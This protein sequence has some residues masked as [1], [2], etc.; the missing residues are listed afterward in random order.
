MSVLDQIMQMKGQGISDEE[1]VG[2]LAQQGI[3]PK[4]INDALKQAQIKNAV[5][6]DDEQLQPSIAQG[7]EAP[8]PSQNYGTQEYQPQEAYQ[9]QPEASQQ[10]YYAAEGGGQQQGYAPE[11][12]NTDTVMEIADQVFSDKIKKIQKQVDTTS[13]T[14]NLLQ[15]KTDNISERLKKIESII[16]RL[17]MSIL[18]KIGSY[19]DN[20]E[21]IKNE[22]SMMQDS[23]TKMVSPS[24]EQLRQQTYP[25]E[26]TNEMGTEQGSQ[27]KIIRKK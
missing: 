7:G 16:D 22:M 21:N 26:E 10:Q 3:S 14:T 20:L 18:D 8:A 15:T 19:G 6:Y 27:G 1:I 5:S 24:R 17:Q 13:E 11:G 25:T 4:E 9:Q 12:V 23:F 2:Q